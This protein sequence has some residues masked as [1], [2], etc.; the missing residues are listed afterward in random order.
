MIT[1]IGRYQVQAELGRGGFGRVYR[2][3]DPTVDRHVAIKTLTA[4]DEPEM[5]KRFRNE[6]AA[7][8]KLRHPNIILIHDFGE[9]EGSPFL[10]MELLDGEDLERIIVKRRELTLLKKLEVMMKAAAGLHHAHSQGIVH[11][12]IKPANIMLL[13]DGNVKILDFGIALLSEASG[14][15]TPQGSVLGTLPYMAP[16]QLRGS[17]SDALSDIFAYG[18]TFYRL[19]TGVHP[20]DAPE[21]A[22]LMYNIIH[23]APASVRNFYPDAPQDL[24]VLMAKILEKDRD[25][26]YQTLEDV[27]FDLESIVLTLRKENVGALLVEARNLLAL[28]R[29][30]TAQ[31]VVRQVFE[32]DPGNRTAREL[33]DQLQ[34]QIKER[35]I[36]PRVTSLVGS[37]R[38]EL[39]A[40]QYDQ[41]IQ[42]FESALRLDKSNPE[43]SALL[44]Q[45]RA[46]WGAAK[47]AGTL[48]DQARQELRL[49]D[50]TAA[51]A[52]LQEALSTDPRNPEATPL[53]ENVRQQLDARQEQQRL[54]DA[55]ANVKTLMLSGN[56]T[57]AFQGA[58]QL[59]RAFP[60]SSE[61][62]KLLEKASQAKER[63]QQLLAGID[64]AKK[65]VRNKHLSEA[66]QHLTQL[67]VKFPDAPELRAQLS[68]ATELLQSVRTQQAEEGRERQ[69]RAT[70]IHSALLE[71]QQL[72]DSGDPEA[73]IAVLKPAIKQYAGEKDLESLLKVAQHTLRMRAQAQALTLG[74]QQD[75][76]AAVLTPGTRKRPPLKLVAA[77]LCGAVGIAAIVVVPKL[78]SHRPIPP[79][80]VEIRTSPEGTSVRIGNQSCV[81][82]A[83][84]L[85][86]PPGQYQLEARLD[87]YEPLLQQLSLAP[88]KTPNIVDL[89]LQPIPAP[90][91]KNDDDGQRAIG[92]GTLIV[93][94]GVA[95]ATVYIDGTPRGRTDSKGAL[96]LPLDP[97]THEVRVE[98]SGYRKA[99]GQRVELA[100]GSNRTVAFTLIPEAARLELR[101][102]PAGV[103]VSA[104]GKLLGRTD[105][106]QVFLFPTPV[107][108]GDQAIQFTSAA[109]KLSAQ[110][111]FEPGQ[112]VRLDWKEIAPLPPTSNAEVIEKQDW[113]RV[114]NATDAAQFREFIRLHPNSLHAREAEQRVADLLWSRVDRANTEAVR[115]FA[116]D[117]PGNPHLPEA[118]KILD[119][120]DTEQRLAQERARQE[121]LNQERIRQELAA[122]AKGE[123]ERQSQVKQQV[124]DTLKQLD[125]AVQRKRIRD[126][127]AIWPTAPQLFLDSLGSSR[128]KMSLA[129]KAEGVRFTDSVD[130][131]SVQ[132]DLITLT[133]SSSQHQS[134]TFA[135]HIKD[136]VWTIETA[137]FE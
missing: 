108:V 110:R 35:E 82:P 70:A 8:G 54:L 25:S 10:V 88:G 87:G 79:V 89:T 78:V 7:A 106:S 29:L 107:T 43:L 48:V 62:E 19:V 105:G 100:E 121:Q 96:S 133:G 114:R 24:E 93:Q 124:L 64:S 120:Y 47:R 37:G 84:R 36:R 123:Q 58:T 109:A 6:A 17:V 86:L 44:E 69:R 83:C 128:V 51:H 59:H 3:Y 137:R 91:P 23:K 118:Q 46:E 5:L 53:L 102:A 75:V 41:A 113:D 66:E 92:T 116:K 130:R 27:H 134:A 98:R 65:L 125:A 39:S 99:A 31:S 119:Q 101:N 127:K 81:V 97:K 1:Q 34:K 9:H 80:Q 122:K 126:V 94:T 15:L 4:S 13:A 18:V 40:R 26:R 28:D 2:A 38:Q 67:L 21:A 111:R 135:L 115:Q 42:K 112:T 63:L 12:D 55:L 32:M 52:H 90:P 45:A 131:V 76:V 16:E 49:G 56:C 72:L 50:L 22:G 11:R 68:Q 74:P 33:R 14:R 77:A 20:F 57:E 136:G 30:D 85:S 103:A 104:G 117:N 61:A 132:C 129:S 60:Q 73:A 71:A 95:D